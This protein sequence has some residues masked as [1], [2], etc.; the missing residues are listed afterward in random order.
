MSP[1]YVAEIG[2]IVLRPTLTAAV[3]FFIAAG[4][5]TAIGIG[6]TRFPI[7]S[8]ASY[9]VIFAAQWAFAGAVLLFSLCMPESPWYLVRHDK[10]DHARKSLHRLRSTDSNNDVALEEIV[11]AIEIERQLQRQQKQA[12]YAH[13]FRDANFRRTRITCGM[14]IVQQFTGIAF[15][16]QALYFLGIS[17]LP[18]SLTFKLALGGFGTAMLGTMVSWFLMDRIGTLTTF[19]VL[20]EQY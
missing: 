9:R 19:V 13:C 15:Y 1:L 11:A 18:I 10:I 16:A 4:Q 7:M 14:F 8:P 20:P 2:P 5:L 12:S 17:G 3:N 6:N